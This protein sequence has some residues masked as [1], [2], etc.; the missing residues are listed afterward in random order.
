M[1]SYD[2][3]F[4]IPLECRPVSAIRAQI[5]LFPSVS[6]Y[7][8]SEILGGLK[9]LATVGA[10]VFLVVGSQEDSQSTVTHTFHFTDTHA[11]KNI[12]MSYSL[13]KGKSIN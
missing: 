6:Q 10:Q 9:T 13:G 7:V 12:A 4:E 3:H 2:M 11:L 1:D 5:R 8:S